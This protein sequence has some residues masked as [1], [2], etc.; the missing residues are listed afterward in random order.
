MPKRLL[1][2]KTARATGANVGSKEPPMAV[3]GDGTMT[4][5]QPIDMSQFDV[6]VT[7][8][9]DQ[10]VVSVCGEIDVSSAPKLRGALAEAQARHQ[11]DEEKATVVVDLSG[12]TYMDASGLGVLVGAAR[13]AHCDGRDIVL[14]DPSPRTLRVLQI[15]RLLHVFQFDWHM[16]AVAALATRKTGAKCMTPRRNVA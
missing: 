7:I 10:T 5:A 15:S 1:P 9:E 11:F 8:E 14:R 16:G 2:A 3:E 4:T 13:R 12:V 6:A